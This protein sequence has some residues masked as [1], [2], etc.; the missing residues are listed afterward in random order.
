MRPLVS[1]ILLVRCELWKKSSC[2]C[3]RKRVNQ[4]HSWGWGWGVSPW[5]RC[6]A[7]AAVVRLSVSAPPLGWMHL[8]LVRGASRPRAPIYARGS[9]TSIFL[10]P[11]LNKACFNPAIKKV[12]SGWRRAHAVAAHAHTSPPPPPPLSAPALRVFSI[13]AIM[14]TPKIAFARLVFFHSALLSLFHWNI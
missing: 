12:S 13:R 2:F 4:K 7:P 3:R 5:I 6:S 9:F 8:L 14:Q 11:Q 1:H 10:Y